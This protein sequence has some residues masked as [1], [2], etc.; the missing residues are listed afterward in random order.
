M[1]LLKI[2][3]QK[4]ARSLKVERKLSKMDVNNVKYRCLNTWD[5][6][7]AMGTKGLR[8]TNADLKIS[9]YAFVHKKAKPLNFAFLILRIPEFFA[10]EDCKFLWKKAN[11]QHI[12]LFLNVCQ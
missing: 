8:Y 4:I 6:H 2:V 3:Q 1:I 5:S 9:L 7:V 12:L 11:F 10:R